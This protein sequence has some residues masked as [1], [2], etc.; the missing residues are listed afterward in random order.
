MSPNGLRVRSLAARVA[1]LDGEAE[2]SGRYLEHWRAWKWMVWPQFLPLCLLLFSQKVSNFTL[3]HTMTQV[4][5]HLAN[6][7][8]SRPSK[9][10]SQNQPFLF[11]KWLSMI[12]CDSDEKL[13]YTGTCWKRG[14][15]LRKDEE[16]SVE[17]P[18]T[19]S[20][21]LCLVDSK[22]RNDAKQAQWSK[23]PRTLSIGQKKNQVW[24]QSS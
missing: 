3:P 4:Q 12:L 2:P 7:L 17:G 18:G 6:Q 5:S 1:L 15:H 13:T 24:L 11:I 20:R 9:T 16:R 8:W 14:G 22:G 19:G 23:P 10:I 21:F